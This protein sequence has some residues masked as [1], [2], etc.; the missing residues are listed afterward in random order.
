MHGLINRAVQCFV[1]D[2]YGP[3]RWQAV[4]QRIGLGPEGFETMLDYDDA[5]T[6]SLLQAAS[7]ALDRTEAVMLEDMGTYLVSH[8]TTRAVRRLLRFSGET[9]ADVLYALE[10][11]PSRAP[12]ALPELVLPDLELRE[13]AGGRFRL[14]VIATEPGW[15]YVMLGLLRAMADDYG[16]LVV[17]EMGTASSSIMVIE[18]RLL[19][20]EFAEG[21][22]FTLADGE[23]GAP[24][25]EG[26][27]P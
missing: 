27:A 9:F 25:V 16:A 26:G 5:V 1:L 23:A 24:T 14:F 8:E 18:I 22:A 3:P 12:L 2:T 11:L 20:D 21:K 6:N 13:E 4:T 15:A 10:D 7:E 17:I 19:D